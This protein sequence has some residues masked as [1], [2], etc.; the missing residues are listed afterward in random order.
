MH[1]FLSRINNR[2]YGIWYIHWHTSFYLGFPWW[3]E[4]QRQSETTGIFSPWKR[5]LTSHC[6][7]QMQDM[8]EHVPVHWE[9]KKKRNT[10]ENEATCM[11]LCVYIQYRSDERCKANGY[12]FAFSCK[13]VCLLVYKHVFASVYKFVCLLVQTRINNTSLIP[14]IWSV[15][16]LFYTPWTS[17]I[18]Y[19]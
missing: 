8:T 9:R 16:Y 6:W 17:V 10:I 14:C 13:R 3:Q 12:T 5:P 7:R 11:Y 18:F 4:D 15:L 19:I 1:R 2:L